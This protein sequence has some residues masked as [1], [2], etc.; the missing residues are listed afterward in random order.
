MHDALDVSLDDRDLHD[1]LSLTT[2]LIIAANGA[3]SRLS[4]EQV[5]VLLGLVGHPAHDSHRVG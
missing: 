4:Q 5:D 2:E 1:E 3:A